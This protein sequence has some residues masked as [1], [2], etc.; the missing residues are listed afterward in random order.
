MD[1]L[2]NEGLQNVLQNIE[3][4]LDEENYSGSVK[5]VGLKIERIITALSERKRALAVENEELL[6]KMGSLCKDLD[7]KD[8]EINRKARL[9]NNLVGEVEDVMHCEE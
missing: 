8:D 9:V 2:D 7:F 4:T 6:I 5:G 1:I 3:E